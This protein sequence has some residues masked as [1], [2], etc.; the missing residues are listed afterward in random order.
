MSDRLHVLGIRHHGPGSAASVLRAL[1][2]TQPGVVLV[3]GPPEGDELLPWVAR[4]LVPPV[5]LLVHDRDEPARAT[6]FPFA[7]Y[8][9]EWV[10]IGWALRNRVPVRSI[11][12]PAAVRL[13]EAIEPAPVV[14]DLPSDEP[15][16]EAEDEAEVEVASDPLG[17]LARLDG[18]EDGEAWWNHLI[19][20]SQGDPEVF[21][22]VE[23]AMRALREEM[24]AD[25]SP[26]S[27]REAAREA[28]MRQ[29]VRA[30]LRETDDAVVAVVGAWHAPFVRPDAFTAKH[31]RAVLTG[32]K[33]AKVVATWVPWTDSRLAKASGYGAGVVHPGWYQSLWDARK[34]ALAGRQLATPFQTR[35]AHTLREAG[36]LAPTSSVIDAVRLTHAL[37]AVR[38]LARP[39]LP[40]LMDA[41]VAT[42]CMGDDTAWHLVEDA[43][44]VGDRVGRVPEDVPQMPLAADLARQQKKLKLKPTGLDKDVKLDL[45]SEA[46]GAKS[47]L[48]HRLDL[49]GVRWGRLVDS[50]RSRGTF[51]ENWR[52][53]WEPE[54]AVALAEAL[55][56]G[57]TVA[58]AAAVKVAQDMDGAETPSALAEQIRRALLAHLDEAATHGVA[59]LQA[60][61]ATASDLGGLAEAVGPLVDVLRYGTAR[62]LPTAGLSDLVEGL[63]DRTLLAVPHGVRDLEAEAAHE[64]HRTLVGFD[65]AIA[66]HDDGGR[67]DDWLASLDGVATDD[68]ASPLLMGFATRRLADGG[69]WDAERVAT[70]LAASL[71]PGFPLTRAAGWLEGFLGDAALVLLHDP[72]LFALVDTWL[73][74]LSEDE[75]LE[76]LPLFRRATSGF[77]DH[78]RRE[79]L[80]RARGEVTEVAVQELAESTP[81]FEAG[82]P[83]LRTILGLEDA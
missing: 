59:R 30:A 62:A 29:H 57:T 4:G 70:A 79:I 77:S 10:A 81:A 2:E 18:Y 26:R 13:H 82:L 67:T 78:Q 56:Y 72:A 22:H 1:D 23:D 51:R 8:S 54:H 33:K 47:V 6:F 71:S 38:G 63:V 55:P 49:L 74:E 21:G 25:D 9:P 31:D 76:A 75:L 3:E 39:G 45:R 20:E 7:A 11:D 28:A 41:S 24:P 66:R 42:L 14:I 46:G 80:A 52:L 40:E 61:A 32:L 68:D 53:R 35:V 12:L 36:R 58:G 17:H 16:D 44:L 48:L 69:A 5:A 34:D 60:V 15:E 27:R 37:T 43:L 19:E 50:G 65:Q 73:C 64:L 83:L